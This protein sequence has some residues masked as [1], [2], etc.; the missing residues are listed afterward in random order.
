ME[1][2]V[3]IFIFW[4][5]QA[6]SLPKSYDSL[7]NIG[8]QLGKT[9]FTGII[10]DTPI[11]DKMQALIFK[12]R[13]GMSRGEVKKILGT[14]DEQKESDLGK[15]NPAKA[16]QLQDIWTWRG[17]VNG[18]KAFIM[19]SF[20]DGKLDDGGTPYFEV[21]KGFHGKKKGEMSKKDVRALNEALKLMGLDGS[22]N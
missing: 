16:G 6:A 12:V 20:I 5:S 11:D 15:L 9:H 4:F 3:L 14:P 2:L 18:K 8:L 1:T 10:V 21:G 17:T 7:S 13:K 19:L 22:S